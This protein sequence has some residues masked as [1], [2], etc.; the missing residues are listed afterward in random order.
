[1]L[2]VI[3]PRKLYTPIHK[4]N[5][6]GTPRVLFLYPHGGLIFS[7]VGFSVNGNGRMW[8]ITVTLSFG[9]VTCLLQLYRTKRN[10][11][12]F[13]FNAYDIPNKNM[14]TAIQ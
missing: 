2:G 9:T 5:P 14:C 10:P 1:M 11:H 8:L 7:T 13:M 12:T 4:C 6:V 3:S